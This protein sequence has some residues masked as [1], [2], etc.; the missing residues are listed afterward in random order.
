MVNVKRRRSCL[1]KWVCRVAI[2]LLGIAGMICLR[3]YV[4]FAL[5]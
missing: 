3:P 1:K 2:S 4:D 5:E